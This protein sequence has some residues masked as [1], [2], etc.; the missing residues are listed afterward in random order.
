PDFWGRF[1]GYDPTKH[2]PHSINPKTGKPIQYKK[3]M[4]PEEATFAHSVG[5]A[6]LP[7]YFNFSAANV[8]TSQQGQNYAKWAI[9][10]ALGRLG[11]SQGVAIFVDIEPNVS[12]SPDFIQ[13]WYD[14]FNTSFTFT[15]GKQSFKYDAGYYKAG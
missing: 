8:T 2:D 11:I 13:G 5:L 7:I 3:D 12:P 9:E 1:I 4:F 6:I 10:D 15:N 14:Q